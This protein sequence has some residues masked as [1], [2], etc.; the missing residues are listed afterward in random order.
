MSD[1]A[2]GM[3][4]ERARQILELRAGPEIQARLAAL[5]ARADE[6]QLSLDEETEHKSMMKVMDLLAILQAK[7]HRYLDEHPGS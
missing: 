6:G 5:A 2:T 1:D 3:T 7:G 4:P